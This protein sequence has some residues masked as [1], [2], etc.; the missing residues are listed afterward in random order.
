MAAPDDVSSYIALA[1]PLAHPL[2]FLGLELVFSLCFAVTICDVGVRYRRGERYAL[3]QWLVIFAY[4][5]AMELLAFN[6]FPDYEHGQ[7]TAQLYHHKLPLYVTFV[8]V[9]FHYTGL[10]L[11]SRWRLGPLAEAVASGL[12]ILLLDV[13]FDLAGAAAEWWT[14]HPS[15]HDVAQRWLGVP[16][17]SY[18]WYLLFGAVLVWMCRAVRG[19]VERR[20]VGVYVVLAPFV[21]V[22]IIVIGIIGFLP[23]HALEA[24]GVPDGGIVAAHAAFAAVVAVRARRAGAQPRAPGELVAIPIALAGWNIG[25]IAVLWRLGDAAGGPLRL[26]VATIASAA[27]LLLFVLGGESAADAPGANVVSSDAR[28]AGSPSR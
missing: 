10:R 4:G 15:S 11:V 8:Y 27:M 13:P 12:A 2:H 6:A 21:A 3:F 14:W 24:L 16:L 28:A 17:T 9:V 20:S 22:A 19:R 18:E 23:F 1:N 5:V 26:A 25:V 7:F